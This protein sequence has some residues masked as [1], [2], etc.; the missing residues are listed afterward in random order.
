MRRLMEAKDG[1]ISNL[2]L[3]LFQGDFFRRFEQVACQG[4]PIV[5]FSDDSPVFSVYVPF[6]L[7]PLE[8]R[9]NIFNVS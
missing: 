2:L 8:G 1:T 7:K 9:K 5:L 3:S 4:L 6:S